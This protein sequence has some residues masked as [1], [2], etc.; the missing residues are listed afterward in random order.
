[1]RSGEI[2]EIY[3]IYGICE[4]YEIC[5]VITTLLQPICIYLGVAFL[6]AL[7]SLKTMFKTQSLS[8]SCFQDCKISRVLQS[9]TEYYIVLHSLTECYSVL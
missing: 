7:A 6:D 3:E 8:D 4:I 5:E 1:M 2:R 9:I